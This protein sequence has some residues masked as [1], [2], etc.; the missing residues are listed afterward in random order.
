MVRSFEQLTNLI[1]AKSLRCAFRAA[2]TAAGGTPEHPRS[3][4]LARPNL[5]QPEHRLPIDSFDARP[6]VS[7][8]KQ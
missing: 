6:R 3:V 8:V 2:L 4:V 7:R 5:T 1:V